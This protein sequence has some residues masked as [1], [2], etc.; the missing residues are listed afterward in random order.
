M[1]PKAAKRARTAK[2]PV[3]RDWRATLFVW[4]GELFPDSDA[5]C[6]VEWIGNWLGTDDDTMPS[7]AALEASGNIFLLETEPFDDEEIIAKGQASLAAKGIEGEVAHSDIIFEGI[8]MQ[9]GGVDEEDPEG[10]KAFFALEALYEM[11]FEGSYKLDGEMV[12]DDEHRWTVRSHKVDLPE[13]RGGAGMPG[14][15]AAVAA[16]G[17]TPFGRFISLGVIEGTVMTL[18]RRY[19]DDDDPRTAW[20]SPEAVLDA[21]LGDAPLLLAD[22]PAKLPWK[23][24]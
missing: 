16:V 21:V 20:A 7:V 19:I 4:R 5:E 23:Q 1:P 3:E 12:E 17:T 6:R 18:A 9:L 24:V 22:I 11:K 10:R 14:D 8:E 13:E 15:H 2:K